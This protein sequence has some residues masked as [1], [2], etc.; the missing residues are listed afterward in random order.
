MKSISAL[1]HG[2]FTGP[3][4]LGFDPATGVLSYERETRFAAHRTF[5]HHHGRFPSDERADGNDRLAGMEPH[6]APPFAREYK[7]KARTITHNPFFSVTR[8]TAYAAAQTR[9]PGN[10]QPKLG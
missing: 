4:V 2:I 10:W 7:E 5:D 6:V 1:P 9:K 8:L 3:G